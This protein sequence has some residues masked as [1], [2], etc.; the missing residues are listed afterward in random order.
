MTIERPTELTGLKR[1]TL[2]S[3]A[4]AVA[5]ASTLGSPRVWAQTEKNHPLRAADLSLASNRVVAWRCTAQP[6]LYPKPYN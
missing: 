1:R 5:A 4:A 2:L 6:T 3:G